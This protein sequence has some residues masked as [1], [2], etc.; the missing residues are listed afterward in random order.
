[1]QSRAWCP[2]ID[3]TSVSS[4]QSENVTNPCIKVCVYLAV[5]VIMAASHPPVASGPTTG[6]VVEYPLKLQ[7]TVRLFTNN[8]PMDSF[9]NLSNPGDHQTYTYCW[10]DGTRGSGAH[11]AFAAQG[12]PGV[13]N[14]NINLRQ[15]DPDL[16]KMQACMRMRDENT[17]NLRTVTLA[18]SAVDLGKLLSGEEDHIVMCDQ[19]IEGNYCELTI[20]LTNAS[21]YANFKGP[22]AEKGL[23]LLPVASTKPFIQ[24]KPSSLRS[25]KDINE[26]VTTVSSRF[27]DAMGR[28]NVSMAKGGAPF[29]RGVTRSVP[30]PVLFLSLMLGTPAYVFCPMTQ[31]GVWRP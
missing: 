17:N 10:I 14:L 20:R 8:L 12:A 15:E 18:V 7:G 16:L 19:F 9:I 6:V 13:F 27:I 21:D 2:T 24:L 29:Y 28:F 3:K 31:P 4:C 23:G 22:Q 1:M 5:P 25:L 11:V 30:T 26:Q